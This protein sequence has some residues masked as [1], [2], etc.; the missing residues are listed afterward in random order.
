MRA[1]LD[2]LS[3]EDRGKL[4][5]VAP[6]VTMLMVAVP[7]FFGEFFMI[8]FSCPNGHTLTTNDDRAGTA[9]K[10]PKCQVPV[11]VPM[12]SDASSV[13]TGSGVGATGVGSSMQAALSGSGQ[14]NPAPT[15]PTPLA[16][17]MIVFLCPNGHKLNGPAKLKGKAGQCPHCGAKFRIPEDDEEE[18]I[19]DEFEEV[20]EEPTAEFMSEEEF[21]SEEVEDI[22]EITEFQEESE[23][24]E[25]FEEAPPTV[26]DAFLSLAP[27]GVHPY[28]A[29]IAQLWD[30]KEPGQVIE[31]H[32]QKGDV[33][34]PELFAETL[35]QPHF[36]MFGRRE[37]EG[38][39][40][41]IMLP[42]ENITRI[43][44]RH[45]RQVPVGVLK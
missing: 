4:N 7:C 20:E 5:A 31:L 9:A 38:G 45:V 1:G 44:V 37:K 40:T 12:A 2:A 24:L 18:E 17:G 23:D 11:V 28:A 14:K 41:L 39:H 30:A 35:S 36:G 13:A 19:L 29:I 27:E 25:P 21:A 42:W 15:D 22:D 16:P 34:T 26:I 43:E 32:L 6:S 8:K 3:S 33:F 10:C